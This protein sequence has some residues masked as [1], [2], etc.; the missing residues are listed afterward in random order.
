MSAVVLG[1][2]SSTQ[3]TKV[4]AR[5]LDS[6]ALLAVGRAPHP[7]TSAPRSE[8][9]PESW[10]AAL[11]E[12]IGQLGAVRRDVVALA[13]GAQQHGLVALDDGGAV[14]RPAKLWNDTTSAPE[15]A[16]LV[17]AHGRGWWANRTGSV[18]VAS[19][20]VTKVAWMRGHEPHLHARIARVMLPH[21]YLT[22]RL[23]GAHVTDRGDA[24]GTGWWGPA[25]YDHEVLELVGLTADALPRVCAPFEPVGTV[26]ASMAADLNLPGESSSVPAPATTW[27][28]RSASPC[29]Q[30]TLQCRSEHRAPCTASRHAAPPTRRER[31]RDSRM[32]PVATCRWC[33]R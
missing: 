20:T 18:P 5:A 31:L 7:P 11:V 16:E 28:R 32:R 15:A 29:V 22:W 27:P 10:W 6:G 33:A 23:T 13:I 24:S 3:S 9:H 19:F 8:Q 4:E 2:D 26:L 21:D 30:A 25:G 14:L 12:A 1:V 17:A